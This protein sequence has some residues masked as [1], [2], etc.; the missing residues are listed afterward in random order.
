MGQ[1]SKKAEKDGYVGFCMS[2]Y[3]EEHCHDCHSRVECLGL[4]VKE[5]TEVDDTVPGVK[6]WMV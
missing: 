6:L 5:T 2:C 3:A 4:Y 1:I